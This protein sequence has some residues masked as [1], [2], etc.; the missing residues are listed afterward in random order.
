MEDTRLEGELTSWGQVVGPVL[1]EA[2]VSE[3][4][5]VS[6]EDIADLVAGRS[7]LGLHTR[8]GQ[9]VYPEFQFKNGRVLDGLSEVLGVAV[10]VVDDW[11]LASWLVVDQ[12]T[13]GRSIIGALGESGGGAGVTDLVLSAVARWRR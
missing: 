4:L 1:T 7:L 13:L 2:Q 9:L 5:G 3:M 12:P 10:G 8:D 11:T 6:S